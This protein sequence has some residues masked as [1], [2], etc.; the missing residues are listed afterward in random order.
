MFRN[1]G[2]ECGGKEGIVEHEFRNGEDRGV[3]RGAILKGN[4][5]G[6]VVTESGA[7]EVGRGGDNV[8]GATE[9][10]ETPGGEG[11]EDPIQPRRG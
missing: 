1:E 9:L 7:G 8:R 4:D 2:M 3:F 6:G 10:S 5:E 11:G